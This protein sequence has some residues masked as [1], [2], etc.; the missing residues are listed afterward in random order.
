MQWY[1]DQEPIKGAT[2]KT[3]KLTKKMVSHYLVVGVTA[4]KAGFGQAD[5]YTRVPK[6][7]DY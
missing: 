1:L 5:S 6:Q 3:L 7:I 2:K 4:H